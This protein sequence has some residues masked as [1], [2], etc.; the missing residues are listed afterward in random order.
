[1]KDGFKSFRLEV[2]GGG[3]G[4]RHAQR[5]MESRARV[6]GT[7]RGTLAMPSRSTL[8]TE[9]SQSTA[10]IKRTSRRYLREPAARSVPS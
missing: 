4:A 9:V 2:C 8:E 5:D 1:M 7:H 6:L 3:R 10:K